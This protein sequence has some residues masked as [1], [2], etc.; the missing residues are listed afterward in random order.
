[1]YITIIYIIICIIL[2]II[3]FK[4][5][6]FFIRLYD[7]NIII[8]TKDKKDSKL[9]IILSQ[10]IKRLDDNDNLNILEKCFKY[11]YDK[12][13]DIYKHIDQESGI[14]QYP[15]PLFIEKYLKYNK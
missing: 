8:Q 2:Y 7:K 14:T 4:F 9:R 11:I 13:P 10:L 6:T 1:M 15:L 12:V 5:D 3:I